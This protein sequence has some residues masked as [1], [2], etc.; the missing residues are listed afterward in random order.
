MLSLDKATVAAGAPAN[1]TVGAMSAWSV[2][3]QPVHCTWTVLNAPGAFRAIAGPVLATMAP[4]L[5]GFYSVE[6]RAN[7]VSVPFEE[8]AWFQIQVLAPPAA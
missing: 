7:G 6:V 1:T 2:D 4:L 8:E 3:Q 5:A